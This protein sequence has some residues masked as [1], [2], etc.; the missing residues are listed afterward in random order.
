MYV[1]TIFCIVDSFWIPPSVFKTSATSLY[2]K[3]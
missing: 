2:L 3:L 1:Q